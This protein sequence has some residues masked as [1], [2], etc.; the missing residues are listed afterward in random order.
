MLF[1]VLGAP[2]F[3]MQA[4][5]GVLRHTKQ[6]WGYAEIQGRR[7]RPA[8][9]YQATTP[10]GTL[11]DAV[12]VFVECRSP[13]DGEAIIVDHHNPGDP[14]FGKPPKEAWRASSIGQVY[15]LLGLSPEQFKPRLY[16]RRWDPRVIAAADHCLRAAFEGQVPGVTPFMVVEYRDWVRAGFLKVAPDQYKR[17]LAKA[18]RVIEQAP[19]YPGTKIKDLRG[20]Y[21]VHGPVQEAQEA[22]ARLGV[23]ILYEMPRGDRVQVGCIGGTPEEIRVFMGTIAP[24]EGLDNVYGDPARG[25]AG[26]YR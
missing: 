26:G 4:I 7:V 18:E 15:E 11:C 19:N 8:E 25:F 16:G 9:A 12:P 2:D 3:E 5:Q 6:K 21:Q 13:M 22:A 23:A 10:M 14:G 20:W 1:F 17:T 24:A